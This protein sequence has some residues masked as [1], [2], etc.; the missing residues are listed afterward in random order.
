MKCQEVENSVCLICLTTT[1]NPKKSVNR[2][3]IKICYRYFIYIIYD[4]EEQQIV[5]LEKK[6]KASVLHFGD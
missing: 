3:A 1:Q 6:I 5:T 4:E 2:W